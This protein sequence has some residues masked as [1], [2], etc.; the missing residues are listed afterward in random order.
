MPATIPVIDFPSTFPSI[1][2]GEEVAITIPA[3][4]L[5]VI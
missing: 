1:V 2:A 4:V 5:E 3:S